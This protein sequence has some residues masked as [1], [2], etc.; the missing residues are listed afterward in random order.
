MEPRF[1]NHGD[2]LM[3]GTRAMTKKCFNGATVLQPWRHPSVFTG[4]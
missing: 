3:A 2:F 1:F 4:I